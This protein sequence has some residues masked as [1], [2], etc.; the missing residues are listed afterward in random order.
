MARVTGLV[1]RNLD[2]GLGSPGGFVEGNLEIVPEVR[3]ALRSAAPRAAEEI[4]ESEHV[5]EA[6]ENVLEAVEYCGVEAARGGA[7]KAGVPEAVVHVALVAVGQHRVRLGGFLELVFSFLAAGIAVR[8]ELEG[9]LSVRALDF[10]IVRLARD[11]KDLVV[12][13]PAHALATLTIAGRR[14]RSPSL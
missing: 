1:A 4:A 10:L 2:G 3:A 13:A 12:V 11:A 9:K 6:A 8:V 5:S 7:A 14:S